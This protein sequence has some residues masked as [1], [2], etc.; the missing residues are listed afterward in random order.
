M[1]LVAAGACCRDLN[2]V[3]PLVLPANVYEPF[4]CHFFV[5]LHGAWK[6][7][8]KANRGNCCAHSVSISE[9]AMQNDP[10]RANPA[11]L[12]LVDGKGSSSSVGLLQIRTDNGEFGTVCGMNLDAADVVCRQLGYDFGSVSSSPC[13]SY[14]GSSLCGAMGMPV[15]MKELQCNGGE[16]DIQDCSWHPSDPSCS[17]HALDSIV[18][19]GIGAG[20]SKTEEGALRIMSHD[21]APSFDGEGRLEIFKAGSWAA[22][23]RSGFTPGSKAIACKSMGFDGVKSS[24]VPDDDGC[25]ISEGLQR[26]CMQ[27]LLQVAMNLFSFDR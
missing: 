16:L 10:A 5:C 7:S 27:Q 23:C 8:G 6:V 2:S 3:T 15:A 24:G 19:C 21:G 18:Y 13:G 11:R 25:R 26:Q 17:D 20:A 22:V 14:G 4:E 12:R 1:Q 9:Q